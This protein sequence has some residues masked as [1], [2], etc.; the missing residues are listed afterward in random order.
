[1]KF[2]FYDPLKDKILDNCYI[3]SNKCNIVDM[4]KIET[5]SNTPIMVISKTISGIPIYFSY[6][7]DKKELSLEHT[8]P[9]S[10]FTVFGETLYF[11]KMKV[12][13]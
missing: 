4:K 11:Q 9:P 3:Y 8:H 7:S 10:S 1:M 12:I 2:F 6:S 13:G 5:N